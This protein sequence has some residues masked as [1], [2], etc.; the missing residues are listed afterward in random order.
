MVNKKS[1]L[2]ILDNFLVEKGLSLDVK[3]YLSGL[4]VDSTDFVELP[5]DIVE[6]IIGDAYGSADKIIKDISKKLV[7]KYDLYLGRIQKNQLKKYID[8]RF[9]EDFKIFQNLIKQELDEKI[10]IKNYCD[11]LIKD[12]D[13]SNKEAVL[14]YVINLKNA[15]E[16]E[17]KSRIKDYIVFL[18]SRL[19]SLNEKSKLSLKELFFGS[20]KV[21]AKELGEE[22]FLEFKKFCMDSTPKNRFDTISN[23]NEE[24]I[25][26]LEH[27]GGYKSRNALIYLNIEQ[28]LFDNF[29][30]KEEFY[31]YLFEII[32]KSYEEIQ[33]HK[34]LIITIKDI[35][36]DG[37]NLKWELYAY[38]TLYA[39][40]FIKFEENRQYYNAGNIC[41]D[42]LEHKYK[43]KLTNEEFKA[44]QMYYLKNNDFKSLEQYPNFVNRQKE[45]DYFKHIHTGLT[46][47]D[48]N[49][50]KI[51]DNLKNSEEIKFISNET[52]LL[53]I[54]HKHKVDDRKIPCPVCG[55]LK[56][57]GNSYPE[58]GVKSWECKNPMC[59]A[60][61]KTNRGKRYS[62]RSILMQNATFDFSKTN[63][64]PKNITNNW[65][66]DIVEEWS[67]NGL[68]YMLIKYFTFNNDVITGVNVEDN[69]LFEEIAKNENRVFKAV[70]FNDFLNFNHSKD[71]YEE[72][73][74]NN[75]FFDKFLYQKE[76]KEINNE[77]ILNFGE[78]NKIKLY[79][80][81]SLNILNGIKNNSVHNMVTSPPYYNAREYSQWHN[82]YNYL[83][84]MFN[85]AIKSNEVLVPG[86]VF[87]YNIGDIF[88]NDNLT[89]KSKMG[90][91]RIPLGAFTII[92]FQ[93][94]G[95]ELLDNI[96]WYKGEPQSNR[97]KNDGNYTPYYQRP[98]NCYEHM[99]I[100]KKKGTLHK[101]LNFDEDSLK[102]NLI[103]FTPVFKIFKGGE[104]IYGH[105]APYP[106]KIPLLSTKS[107]TN[108]G[109]IVLDPFLGSGTSVIVANKNNRIG[110]GIEL[111]KEYANLAISKIQ[112]EGLSHDFISSL[113]EE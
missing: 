25:K 91:R 19:I 79:H 42:F 85:I 100:F 13:Y 34:S 92:I 72:F 61:S 109:E 93:K 97:H 76:I 41:K 66:K 107:F 82:L 9:E 10:D 63:Q 64:I 80:G 36:Y 20:E 70:D 69:N 26:L 12:L 105:T 98:A 96:I 49:V 51:S 99:F 103:R 58:L 62:Q 39:E 65:R 15:I 23:F 106:P 37:I 57:S 95:F 87:F 53:L 84:D 52:E 90:E 29:N 18:Y 2:I 89:V 21:L 83:N 46:F 110:I 3:G 75:L 104:N 28:S 45:I 22:D 24:Y 17:D 54:F 44:L 78:N 81:D 71:L 33:N 5:N 68:Y 1:S 38:L 102:T 67:L 40:R 111:N 27:N 8:Y 86:G 112:E 16:K 35:L 101:N 94:A 60:R 11:F 88:D 48:C 108:E 113:D 31:S 47:V 7:K 4:I 14:K 43:F 56:I 50:L 73:S 55:S 32:N 74:N 6:K 77:V 59:S 30:S